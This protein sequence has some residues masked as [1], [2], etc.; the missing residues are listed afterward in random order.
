M[1][2][3]SARILAMI[4]FLFLLSACANPTSTPVVL[5]A[6]VTVSIPTL[7]PTI[8]P[9]ETIVPT[10][11]AAPTLTP[12]IAP[13]QT[14]LPTNTVVPSPTDKPTITLT[15]TP[16]RPPTVDEVL[17]GCPTAAQVASIN[18]DFK[19]SFEADLTVGKFVCTATQG[20]V[21][22]TLMQKRAY[23]ILLVAKQITFSKPLPWTDKSLYAWLAGTIKGIRFRS[24]IPF[25]YCCQPANTI[26]IRVADNEYI[27]LTDRWVDPRSGGG[28][29]DTFVLL[30]HEARHNEGKPHTCG[31][32]D[33]TIG[34][35][36]AWGVQYDL[37]TWLADYTDPAF[38]VTTG[39]PSNYVRTLTKSEAENIRKTRFCKPE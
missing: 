20:S 22:L 17:A 32:N 33:N 11:T 26:D 19:M 4:G 3:N 34:E 16:P 13:I 37:L 30:V 21:D 39:A 14:A 35:L 2:P 28:L 29:R 25:S 23:N 6:T 1:K 7:T 8:A 15:P 9:A 38:F 27:V 18:A 31:A 24:D 5:N 12:T 36:G 10:L